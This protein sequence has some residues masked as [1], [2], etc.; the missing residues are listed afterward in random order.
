MCNNLPTLLWL[1]QL[2]ALEIHPWY[3]RIDPKPDTT[4]P[5]DFFKSDEAL[6]R[7]VLSYPDF[8]VIDLD[9]NIGSA[10]KADG[11]PNLPNRDAWEMTVKAGLALK[12]LLDS[13]G[14]KGHPKTSGKTGLHV[15]VPIKRIYDYQTVRLLCETIGRH[16]LEL[17][18]DIMTM[19]WK[20]AK[21]PA[22]IFFDHNQNVRGKT[23]VSI[24]SPRPVP[25]APVS[26]PVTW[27]E[28]EDGVYPSDFRIENIPGLLSERG[29]LWEGILNDRQSIGG[30]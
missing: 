10:S 18:P 4:L 6:D 5:A 28:L 1:G 14:L 24:Y 21:R 7:S 9:P 20:V 3:S 12:E 11:G 8:M 16:L 17:H 23:L 19:E 30:Y 13:I 29:D 26:F 15:Y 22:K 25:G 2:A 27:K